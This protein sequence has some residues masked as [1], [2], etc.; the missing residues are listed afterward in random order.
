MTSLNCE[1]W[2]CPY[3]YSFETVHAFCYGG[4]AFTRCCVASVAVFPVLTV[5]GP[6]DGECASLRGRLHSHV[7]TLLQVL[8]AHPARAT[9]K[10]HT[11]A[12]GSRTLQVGNME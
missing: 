8:H 9:M 2:A 7:R 10:L 5:T 11:R 6:V 1:L 3:M 4:Q 12:P